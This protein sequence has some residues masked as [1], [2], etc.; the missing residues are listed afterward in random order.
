MGKNHRLLIGMFLAAWTLAVFARAVTFEFVNYDDNIYV[1]ENAFVT[2]GLTWAGARWALTSVDFGNW[3]PLAWLSHMLDVQVYGLTPW[4]HHLTSILIHAANAVLLFLIFNGMTGAR[5]PSAFVAALF[6][7]HPLRLE[8]V[9]WV[10]ERKD[11]LAAFFALASL[12]AYLAYC[13][14]PSPGAYLL[15]VVACALGLAAKP[16]LVP[17]PLAFLILEFWPLGRLTSRRSPGN[18]FRAGKPSSRQSPPV[19]QPDGEAS[20]APIPLGRLLLEK[21][22]FLTLSALAT[23]VTSLAQKEH[24]LPTG[25]VR[26]PLGE[27]LAN[28]VISCWAYIGK[29]LVP[30]G[31]AVFYPFP[32]T[33]IP[34]GK[35]FLALGLLAAI[36]W[37]VIRER[38]RLPFLSMAWLWFLAWLAPVIGIIQVGE[39]AM[40]DRY[41]YL[42]STGIAVAL[43]WGGVALCRAVPRLRVAFAPLA[44]L[45]LTA[46]TI[47]TAAQARYWRDSVSLMEHALAVT[48]ANYIAHNDLGSALIRLG[49]I[50]AAIPHFEAALRIRPRHFTAAYNLGIGNLRIKRFRE[51]AAVLE[52]ARIL[53]PRDNN[54]PLYLGVAYAE[55]G[56]HAEATA[57]FKRVL[58]ADPGNTEARSALALALQHSSADGL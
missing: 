49:R 9:V 19:A 38:R 28:A 7:V 24:Y 58:F 35:A 17:L 13:R 12:R 27:R 42:A 1:Y 48:S 22:P 47:A 26:H 16:M 45:I 36:T 11:V 14:R 32:P 10:S 39:L 25:I 31:L 2:Q 50:E 51:A 57:Q 53:N 55:L 43:V 54:A 46:L 30:G 6:A 33:P 3:H 37:L 4:G 41:T 40:A 29:L 21:V 34:R 5:W 56:R 20:R 44:A 52:K 8:S 23:V 18:R 15:A